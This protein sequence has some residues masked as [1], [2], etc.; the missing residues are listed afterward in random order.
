MTEIASALSS[1][2]GI[3]LVEAFELHTC[4]LQHPVPQAV[5]E[6]G[7]YR[8]SP[9]AG[10]GVSPTVAATGKSILIPRTN[11][12]ELAERVAPAYQGFLRG[13]RRTP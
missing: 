8:L 12:V 10:E 4:A 6:P 11:P 5:E 2:V 3:A 13:T 1:S 9:A 7:R